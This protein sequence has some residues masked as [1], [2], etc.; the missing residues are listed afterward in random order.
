MNIHTYTQ[1]HK[2][3]SEYSEEY[4]IHDHS[5]VAKQSEHNF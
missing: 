3:E 4:E 2:V 5:V 1:I